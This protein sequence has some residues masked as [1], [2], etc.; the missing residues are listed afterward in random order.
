M[1]PSPTQIILLAASLCALAACGGGD[2]DSTTAPAPATPPIAA[3]TFAACFEVTDGVAYTM[4]DPDAGGVSDGVLMVKEAFEGAV[5][6]ASVELTDA[7]SVRRAATYW[8]QESSGIRFWG[9]IDY[10][11]TGVAQTQTLL[12]D[13]FV[14]PLTM[15]AGQ[16]AALSYT[17]T[18]TEGGQ[19][20]TLALQETS[21]FEGSRP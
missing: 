3:P 12:S 14:L 5:R 13:G 18:I 15:Q 10:D 19:T 2:N 8:S 11:E 17:A 7:T 16:S 21:T 4:T 6:R 20:D 9:S 1:K